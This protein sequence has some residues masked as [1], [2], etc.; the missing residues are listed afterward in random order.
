VF[1]V[2]WSLGLE[3][4]SSGQQRE[5]LKVP[6]NRWTGMKTEQLPLLW[7]K[8]CLRRTGTHVGWICSRFFRDACVML[9]SGH[10]PGRLEDTALGSPQVALHQ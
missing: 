8:R 7:P 6:S 4:P 1:T 2:Q 10:K 3:T 9:G 5:L